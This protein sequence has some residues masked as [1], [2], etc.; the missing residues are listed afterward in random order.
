MLP[1][2]KFILFKMA[3]SLLSTISS[4]RS[5][6]LCLKWS[7]QQLKVSPPPSQVKNKI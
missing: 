1:A 6:K 2:V 5:D 4:L 3:C 7:H